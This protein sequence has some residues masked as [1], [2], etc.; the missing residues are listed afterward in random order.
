[1][2]YY[3]ILGVSKNATDA[4]IRK[5]YKKQSMQHHPDRG[6]DEAKFK[7]VNEAYQTLKDPQKRAA[8]DNPQPQYNQHRYTTQ[9]PFGQT[10]SFEDLFS[11]FGF[12][13]TMNR[14]RRNRDIRLTYNLGF[15]DIFTGKPITISYKLPNG[16]DE[17]LST[18]LPPGLKNNDCITF[19][20][21]GDNTYA[22]LPRGNLIL[23]VKVPNHP[24]WQREDDNLRRSF[25]LDIF[26]LI[27]GTE[28]EI[29]TPLG[30]TLMLNIP[31]GTRPGTTFSI[32][33]H[34]VPN[35]NTSRKGNLYI[36]VEG[37]VPKITDKN[38]L[39]KIKD[40][41]NELDSST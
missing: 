33:D 2:D 26:D 13:Q 11:Q 1:M 36:K 25:K 3:S 14:Q 22:H 32:S 23:K 4:E 38:I 8:Y 6:G 39:E 31:Q 24:I 15:N 35:V 30:K 19:A 10:H 9:N 12:G 18:N 16:K 29:E 40:I 27:L 5:A 41:K 21:Y 20:D 17:L 7:E 28:I 34:G 37:V